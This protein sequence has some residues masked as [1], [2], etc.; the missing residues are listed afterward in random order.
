MTATGVRGSV[1]SSLIDSAKQSDGGVFQAPASAAALLYGFPESARTK[2]K[3][4]VLHREVLIGEAL[5]MA[6][7]A[8]ERRSEGIQV[9]VSAGT[10]FENIEET[11]VF[12]RPDLGLICVDR[13]WSGAEVSDLVQVLSAMAVSVVLVA[14]K[15]ASCEL[16]A[17]LAA[18]AEAAVD[19]SDGLD[20]I[21]SMIQRYLR[22][23][24]LMCLR[25]MEQLRKDLRVRTVST[26]EAL[27]TLSPKERAVLFELATGTSPVSIA[28]S[29]YVSIE[30][31]RS[32]IRSIRQKLGV[33]SQVGAVA[34]AYQ[35]GWLKPTG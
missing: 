29:L 1:G 7:A 14:E 5:A 13:H 27:D 10:T 33:T 9:D 2:V 35:A 3:V 19:T 4:L 21:L 31:V 20:K 25:E 11:V 26:C 12:Q 8:E 6:L 15:Q 24:P 28:D 32:H 16:S 34:L 22:G 30:T 17:G 23:E 18:G